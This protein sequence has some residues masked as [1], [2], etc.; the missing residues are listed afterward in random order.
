MAPPRTTQPRTTQPRTTQPPTSPPRDTRDR[1]LA[2]AANVFAEK[3]YD[4][5]RVQEI[6]RRAGLTT[7]AIYRNF[8]DK[9]DLLLAAIE[10]ST[11]RLVQL[12]GETRDAGSGSGR[13][14]SGLVARVVAP[15]RATTRRLLLETLTAARRDN[16]VRARV[17]PLLDTVRAEI[18]TVVEQGKRTG[19]V[20]ADVDADAWAYLGLSI[21]FGSYL[22]EASGAT[23]PKETEWQPL[24]ERLLTT[25]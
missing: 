25:A 7:G 12:L 2:E 3:G 14:L 24:V 15:Q 19:E 4:G 20:P 9:S 5:A 23:V 10:Q 8:A 13:V 22:L 21:A 16:D 11:H 18:A 17:A 6:A 1:L